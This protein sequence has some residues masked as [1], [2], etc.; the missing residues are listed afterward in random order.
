MY[1]IIVFIITRQQNFPFVLGSLALSNYLLLPADAVNGTISQRKGSG[2]KVGNTS[3][4]RNPQNTD[5]KNKR[6]PRYYDLVSSQNGHFVPASENCHLA[7]VFICNKYRALA[8]AINSFS[9]TVLFFRIFVTWQERIFNI[10]F[11]PRNPLYGY[12]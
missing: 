9:S 10:I 12:P 11:V 4:I 7:A 5:Y 2:V 1:S 3:N 6:E 8:S